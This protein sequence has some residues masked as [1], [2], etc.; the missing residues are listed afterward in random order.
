[1]VRD[2]DYFTDLK[3]RLSSYAQLFC[4]HLFGKP[5]SI[6]NGG[7]EI[8]SGKNGSTSLSLRTTPLFY[9]FEVQRVGSLLDAV[10]F[11]TGGDIHA[12]ADFAEHYLCSSARQI[13]YCKPI[14]AVDVAAET[15][16]RAA[17]ALRDQAA[18]AHDT[19]AWLYLAHRGLSGAP[20][21]SRLSYRTRRRA[22]ATPAAAAGADDAPICAPSRT[23]FIDSRTASPR[24]IGRHRADRGPGA[25]Y[26]GARHD[27]DGNLQ[28]CRAA[29][30]SV[31]AVTH[32]AEAGMTGAASDASAGASIAAPRRVRA[33]PRPPLVGV[34]SRPSASRASRRVRRRRRPRR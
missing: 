11:A 13:D 16:T 20:I 3:Q 21:M 15:H 8:R 10:M 34:R 2:R 12:A 1:M 24:G 5:T 4:E 29:G 30:Y 18:C 33:T 14:L 19:P 27:R 26:A 25:L 9:S 32:R 17:R 28:A 7:R 22:P 6:R 23:S 31:A